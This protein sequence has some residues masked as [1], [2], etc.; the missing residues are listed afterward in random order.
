VL[1]LPLAL[2]LEP[3][4][5]EV[6]RAYAEALGC[7]A[8]VRDL[9][10]IAGAHR[11]PARELLWG[12]SAETVHTEGGVRF[13]LDASRV[14]WSKGNVHER[15][16]IPRLVQPGELVVDLFAGIGY[17]AVPVAAK[18]RA[19]VVACEVNPEAFRWLRRNVA[20]NQVKDLVEPRLGDCCEVAPQ[21]QADRVLLGYTVDT[22]AFLPAAL[23]A[24]KP[25]GGVLHYHEACPAHLWQQRPWERVAAAAQ[26]AGRRASLLGQ[27]V[28]KNYAPGRVHV[29][30]D[31][32]VR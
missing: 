8:V 26:Q 13:A 4:K 18:A 9:G 21:A 22:E 5:R 28:V 7:G 23:A 25:A 32:E 12:A 6:A 30:V 24:L 15:Q 29:V 11:E 19:R 20:L 3:W 16:R 10:P 14:M 2:E 27:R 17:F 1:V 31:A